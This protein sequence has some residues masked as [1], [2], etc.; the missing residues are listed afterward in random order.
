MKADAIDKIVSIA[1]PHEITVGA[2]QFVDKVMHHLVEPP[3]PAVACSTLQ[4]LVDLLKA[5]VNGAAAGKDVLVHIASPH[6]VRLI[7][8]EDD[9]AGRRQEY[10]VATYPKECPTF[11]F[12]AWFSTENFIIAVQQG[13]QRVMLQS[14]DG[15]F[16]KD[17][18]Y[19]LK[20]TSK[21]SADSS[22]ANEDDG[23]TQRVNV[24]TGV[25]LKET[26]QLQPRVALAPYRTFAEIDQIVSTFIFRARVGADGGVQLALF[27]GDGGRWRLAAVAAIKAWLATQITDSPIIS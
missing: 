13:F 21:I 4:G 5:G 25:V 20:V 17:L 15:T 22:V 16:A 9:G 12:G 11:T 6:L 26:A 3:E 1:A 14:D 10:A 27:E 23:V 7:A 24:Q 19:V 8:R 2:S 18:D